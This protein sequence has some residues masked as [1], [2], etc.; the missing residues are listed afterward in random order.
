MQHVSKTS[1]QHPAT[2]QA[3]VSSGCTHEQFPRR[4]RLRTSYSKFLLRGWHCA[5]RRKR[6]ARPLYTI[7]NKFRSISRCNAVDWLNFQTVSH[8]R[9]WPSP[10]AAPQGLRQRRSLRDRSHPSVTATTRPVELIP[11]PGHAAVAPPG[12]APKRT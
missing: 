1:I 4:V 11:Q 12:K 3:E 6:R 5:K 2:Q 7:A 9:C 8:M 10:A